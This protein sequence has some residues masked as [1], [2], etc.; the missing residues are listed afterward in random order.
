MLGKEMVRLIKQYNMQ[1]LLCNSILNTTSQTTTEES[2][3]SLQ[4]TL[5]ALTIH[6][7]CV[8]KI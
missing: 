1:R 2:I 6:I 8:W 7:H 5:Q 3:I 4:Y